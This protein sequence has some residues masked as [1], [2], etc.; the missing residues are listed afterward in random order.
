[1]IKTPE[2]RCGAFI[3]NFED[4]FHLFLVGLQLTLNR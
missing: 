2:R 3:V 4:I 1:M